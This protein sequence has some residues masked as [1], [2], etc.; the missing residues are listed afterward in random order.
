MKSNKPKKVKALTRRDFLKGAAVST[1]GVV[2]AGPTIIPSTVWGAN[3]PSNRIAIGMIGT[4]RQATYVNLK[5]FLHSPET[6]VIAVCDVDS[7]RLENAR[8]IVENY[9]NS[10]RATGKFE[11]CAAYKDFRY[12]IAR[13]DIDAVMISTTDHW[14]VPMAIA[15][16]RAGKDICCEKPLSITIAEGRALCDAVRRYRRVFRTDSECRSVGVFRRACELVLNGRIGKLHTIRTAV[17]NVENIQGIEVAIGPQPVMPVPEELDYDMWLGPAPLAPYTQQR[18]HPNRSLKRPG[19]MQISDYCNGMISNWGT[20]LN[21]VAQWGNNTER[22]GPVEIE[23][24]GDGPRDGL[25]N[26]VV[27]FEVHYKYANGVE[28]FYTADRPY[29][30]FEGTDGWVQA[31]WWGEKLDAHPKSILTSVIGP[32]EIHLPTVD[33]KTDFIRSVKTRS[34]TLEP[35]EVGHRTASLCQ[36]GLIAILTGRKLKWEPEREC[37]IGDPAANR[38]LTRSMR[39]P[40]HL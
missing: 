12:I 36:L 37:F 6:Q 17:P 34:Q 26:T 9:Y 15:A 2:L 35:A 24:H 4:G 8:R 19:W 32:D 30:R 31:Q 28:L 23:G 33:E 14:H 16:A 39:A 7:W 11:G 1:A 18:V 27:K 22:T 13:E 40:W 21:D 5:P 25:W 3:A 38:M 29:V 20:H 10:K